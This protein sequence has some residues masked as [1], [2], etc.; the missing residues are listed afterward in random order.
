MINKL[1]EIRKTLNRESKDLKLD[2]I[3]EEI[4]LKDLKQ[5][6]NNNKISFCFNKLDDFYI[7]Y[8][9][10]S[11]NCILSSTIYED[12]VLKQISYSDFNLEKVISSSIPEYI[13][14]KKFNQS[15]QL[16]VKEFKSFLINS[17]ISTIS[18][19][20]VFDKL[21]MPSK[22]DSYILCQKLAEKLNNSI[23]LEK[24]L[25]ELNSNNI[26]NLNNIKVKKI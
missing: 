17:K 22:I 2:I 8:V 4:K 3:L 13:F 20:D 21:K 9:Y 16:D 6:L 11:K 14:Y 5:K 10:F 18:L 23:F 12:Y 26:E 19:L 24:C 7:L 15:I 1:K 25:L